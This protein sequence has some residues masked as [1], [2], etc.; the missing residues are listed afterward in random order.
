MRTPTS[1][2]ASRVER[3]SGTPRSATIRRRHAHVRRLGEATLGLGHRA[4]LAAESDLAEE[5]RIA[6]ERAVVDARRERRRDGEVAGRLLQPHAAD[7]VQE[8]VE[9]RE[10]EPGA[11]VEHRE[12]Q[13]EASPVEAGGDALRRAEAGF[14]GERLHLDEHRARALEQRRDRAARRVRSRGRPGTARRDWRRASSPCS[15]MRNTPISST[16][17]KRFLVARSTR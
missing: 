4:D 1:V 15:V 7:D 9:L 6:R 13:R 10:R 14:R 2:E 3:A 16:L 17:P 8:D 12:Q 5:H 11:L